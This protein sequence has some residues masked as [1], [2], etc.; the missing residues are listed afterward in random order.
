ML[1]TSLST[2]PFLQLLELRPSCFGIRCP[3]NSERSQ[4]GKRATTILRVAEEIDADLIVVGTGER[5][6]ISKLFAPS[7][8][9]AVLKQAKRSVLIV[10]SDS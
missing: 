1:K 3:T 10:R 9:D 6:W 8:S 4:H 7:V 2:Q 5:S